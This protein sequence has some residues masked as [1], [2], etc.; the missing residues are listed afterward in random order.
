MVAICSVLVPG[1][2]FG[3]VGVPVSAGLA[4]GALVSSAVLMSLMFVPYVVKIVDTLPKSLRDTGAP[5]INAV[6][7]DVIAASAVP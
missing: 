4:S 5:L 2:A 3:A 1:D 6:T 7:F